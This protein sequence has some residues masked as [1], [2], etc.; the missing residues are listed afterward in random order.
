MKSWALAARAAVSIASRVASGR[1]SAMFSATLIGNRNG[2]WST[3]ATCW[4]RLA[5]DTVRTSW[6]ST[7]TRPAVGSAKRGIRPTSELL[8]APVWPTTA[9]VSPASTVKLTS[10]STGRSAW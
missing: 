10:R 8:P 4:R 6:P 7:S 3:T 5:S 1:P 2:S 9:I